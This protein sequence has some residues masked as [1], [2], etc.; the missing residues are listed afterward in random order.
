MCTTFFPQISSENQP[1]FTSANPCMILRQLRH[2]DLPENSE[3]E[4]GMVKKKSAVRIFLEPFDDPWSVE[5]AG[6]MEAQQDPELAKKKASY[7][8][9]RAVAATHYARPPSRNTNNLRL[10]HSLV[11]F[12]FLACCASSL[13]LVQALASRHVMMVSLS[14]RGHVIPL[15]RLA[16]E[17]V[18]RG[19]RVSFAVPEDAKD[20]I[21]KTGAKFLP[22]STT[23]AGAERTD[24]LR[25][26]SHDVSFFRGILSLLNDVYLPQSAPVFQALSLLVQRDRPD[27]MVIDVGAL[28]ALDV[29]HRFHIPF[30]V[31]NPSLLFRLDSHYHYIPAWGSGFSQHM[32][33]WKRCLSVLYPR[34][35][36]VA[37]T[38]TFMD[39]NK[40]RY[41]SG[42]PLYESQHDMFKEVLVLTNTAFGLEYPVPLSPLVKMTGPLMPRT[43]PKLPNYLRVW[44]SE[45]V[46]PVVVV[47]FG[48]G[49]MS[50][51]EPWQITQIAAGLEDSRFRVLWALPF[52]D[53]RLA[54]GSNLPTNFVVFTDLPQLAVLSSKTVKVV[55]SPCGVGTTHEALFYAKTILCV[56]VLGDQ[57]DMAARVVDSGSGL[58]LEKNSLTAYDVN[59]AVLSLQRN[60]SFRASAA[61]VAKVLRSSGGTSLAADI[62]EYAHMVGVESL[63]PMPSKLPRHQLC[64]GDIIGL[65]VAV[66][67]ILLL[68]VRFFLL[69]LIAALYRAFRMLP[70]R[71][72]HAAFLSVINF[73]QNIRLRA[74]SL[75]KKFLQKAVGA[76]AGSRSLHAGLPDP[77]TVEG[78]FVATLSTCVDNNWGGPMGRK[79][80]C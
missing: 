37:L 58:W 50:F 63:I 47:L 20:Y 52:E 27:V 9:A 69:I 25:Q 75:W 8:P 51:L 31:N 79:E 67:C 45:S 29:A 6:A 73:K 1:I 12:L 28:G 44:L 68:I 16:S 74:H 21:N 41:E 48:E 54:L 62:V 60:A 71:N 53:Q 32:S 3:L 10:F 39:L 65:L 40:L 14:L 19:N 22:L 72:R 30:I 49:A 34:L 7:A 76:V 56:P 78:A 42:L 5:D 59:E 36:G 4:L 15:A 43:K 66:G 55:V 18:A 13:N 64:H 61:R 70:T 57:S 80:K 38:P 46:T 11:T 35:L 24:K 77:N 33:L 17:L 2:P 26:I 23:L